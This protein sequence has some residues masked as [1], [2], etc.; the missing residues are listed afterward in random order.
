[1]NNQFI[2]KEEIQIVYTYINE[3]SFGWRSIE[4]KRWSTVEPDATLNY[5]SLHANCGL[6]ANRGHWTN[7]FNRNFPEK[8]KF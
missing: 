5:E 6:E 4:S 1:M 7:I 3:I 8:D 2:E